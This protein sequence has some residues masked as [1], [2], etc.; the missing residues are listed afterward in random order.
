MFHIQTF[1]LT[2]N[3]FKEENHMRETTTTD[4]F[5]IKVLKFDHL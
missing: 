4:H 1:P 3:T 5:N 2:K